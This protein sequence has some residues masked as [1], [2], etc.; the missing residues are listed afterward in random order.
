[1]LGLKQYY[2]DSLYRNSI[3]I[4]LSFASLAAFGLLFWIVA[5]RTLPVSDVGLA[6]AAIAAGGLLLTVLRVGVDTGYT[7]FFPQS[8]DKRG[9]FNTYV[10]VTLALTMIPTVLFLVGLNFFAPTLLF[11]R[12]GSFLGAFLLYMG[13]SSVIASQNQ[14]MITI[15]R[16][17]LYL[18]QN[19]V[20]GLRVPLLLVF[21]FGALG[22]FYSLG[23]ASV[24]ACAF[25]AFVLAKEGLAFQFRLNFSPMRK[26]LTYSLGSHIASL[27]AALPAAVIP[28]MIVGVA[29]A[30]DGAYFYIA[31]S[32]AGVLLMIES[33]VS[34]SLFVEGSHDAP[35]KEGVFKSIKLTMLLLVPAVVFV[36]LLGDKVLLLFGKAYSSEALV[37]LQL[38]GLSSLFAAVIAIYISIKKVQKELLIANAISLVLCTLTIGLGYVLLLR[39]GLTGLAVGWLLSNVLVCA[40]VLLML[41]WHDKWFA[42]VRQQ[43]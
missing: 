27:F 9:F 28:V 32:V 34:L 21:S 7:R 20:L 16:S 40:L 35:L 8:S 12:Q 4:F 17:E 37:T 10:V 2:R 29:G 33:A 26:I 13:A 15:R 23:V 42:G 43:N 41:T 30:N 1:M 36:L 25:G 5:A 11:L 6:A 31:Y 39:Y 22:V 14:A 18:E 3:A 38:L 19:L 24:I